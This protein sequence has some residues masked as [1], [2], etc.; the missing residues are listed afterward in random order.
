MVERAFDTGGSEIPFGRAR[1]QVDVPAESVS[2]VAGDVVQVWGPANACG[3][4]DTPIE[5]LSPNATVEA[6]TAG[7]SGAFQATPPT[8]VNLLV[9]NSQVAAV[10]CASVESAIHFV[11][12][13][14]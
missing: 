4:T 6:V 8:K 11:I 10:L 12:A 14:R 7:S 9:A 13:G 3:T 5:L 2:V 1:V